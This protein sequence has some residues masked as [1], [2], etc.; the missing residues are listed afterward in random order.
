MNLIAGITICFWLL[1]CKIKQSWLR[2]MGYK[3]SSNSKPD[4]VSNNELVD[5]FNQ[6]NFSHVKC[7]NTYYSNQL[8]NELIYKQIPF[9]THT[10]NFGIQ[11]YGTNRIINECAASTSAFSGSQHSV[12]K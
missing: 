9:T 3:N 1:T 2:L 8:G 11:T 5:A 4:M 10:D 6:K 7:F 12:S